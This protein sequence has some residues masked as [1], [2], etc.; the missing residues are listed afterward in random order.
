MV[1]HSHQL[2]RSSGMRPSW[3]YPTT[4]TAS[5]FGDGSRTASPDEDRPGR[6][7]LKS[8]IPFPSGHPAGIQFADGI[9][10]CCGG[11][12]SAG[13]LRGVSRAGD[14]DLAGDGAVAEIKEKSSKN[15][16]FPRPRVKPRPKLG[17]NSAQSM[18]SELGPS[19]LKWGMQPRGRGC[20][21]RCPSGCVRTYPRS[22]TRCRR[23]SR[24]PWRRWHLSSPCTSRR[25]RAWSSRGPR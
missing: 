12:D 9:G 24:L 23:S 7:Q 25:S 14:D 5:S 15:Q 18:A 20:N 10:G 1:G 3:T 17:C 4:R 22:G 2:S 19:E 8:F 13:L 6:S 11:A 16:N 21:P